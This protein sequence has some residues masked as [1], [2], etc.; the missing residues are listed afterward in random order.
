MDEFH[1]RPQPPAASQ[2][3]PAAPQPTPAA[4]PA[5]PP[6]P[7]AEPARQHAPALPTPPTRRWF[8]AG[9]LAVLAGAGT[10][11]GAEYLHASTAAPPTKPPAAMVAA[12]AAERALIADLDATTGGTPDVRRSIVQIRADHA[13]HLVALTS[14]LSRYRAPATSPSPAPGTPRTL[15]Q[16]RT[17]EQR[18]SVAAGRRA[19]ALDRSPAAL[20]ASIAACEATHAELLR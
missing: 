1:P 20:L 9:G 11:V 13:A 4:R 10:G 3:R 8:L 14:V 5:P 7:P 18:A 15:A 12:A 6:P 17:A 16:L 2:P 19:A